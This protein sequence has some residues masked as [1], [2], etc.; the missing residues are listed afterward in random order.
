MGEIKDMRNQFCNPFMH[1]LFGL[2]L[3]L[4]VAACREAPPPPP[5]RIRAIKAIT[6]SE[7]A[8]GKLRQF[9]G[10]VEAADSSS[11]SFEVAGNVREV[12]VDVGD[13]IN[14]G[15]VLAVLDK[16]TYNLNVKAAEAENQ[17]TGPRCCQSSRPG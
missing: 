1:M 7:Q 12:R 5:E 9:S 6:V 11:I 4:T 14:K 2:S 3:L 16:R 17:Q 8:A 10:V 13:R 15:Q